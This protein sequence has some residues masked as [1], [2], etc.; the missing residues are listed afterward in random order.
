MTMQKIL[1]FIKSHW[2]PLTVVILTAITIL[3]LS[4]EEKLPETPGSDKLHHYIAYAFLALPV[5]LRRP[6]KWLM[7][8]LIFVAWSGTIELLQPLVNR[9]R[10]IFD[11]LANATGVASGILIGVL[12][13][14]F[15][16]ARTVPFR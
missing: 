7:L 5:A 4:P 15:I 13:N 11:L 9:C 1:N 14:R 12:V 16:R 2:L 8:C 6:R 10:D 3:S